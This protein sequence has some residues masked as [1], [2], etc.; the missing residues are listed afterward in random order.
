MCGRPVEDLT[1]E[2]ARVSVWDWLSLGG[3]ASKG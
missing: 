1:G 2:G 3:G